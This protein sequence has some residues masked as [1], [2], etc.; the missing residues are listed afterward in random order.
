[1]GY[2]RQLAGSGFL[3]IRVGCE[4]IDGQNILGHVVAPWMD[5][6]SFGLCQCIHPSRIERYR[7]RVPALRLPINDGS[8]I[9]SNNI[10]AT[11]EIRL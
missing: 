6:E 2:K 3:S 5:N 7:V 10:F 4:L 11:K 9:K 8:T 1:M